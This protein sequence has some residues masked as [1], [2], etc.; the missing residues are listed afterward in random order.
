MI[1]MTNNS[2]IHPTQEDKKLL[3]Q[4]F[5][6]KDSQLR[7]T[8]ILRFL[9]LVH[10]A[11]GRLGVTTNGH[12]DYVDLVNQGVLGLID[13]VDRYDPSFKTQFSTYAIPKVRG[14]ILDFMRGQ[15]WLPRTARQR[16]KLVQQA[17]QDLW[18]NLHR[19]PT[20]EEIAEYLEIPIDKARQA[21]VD[22]SHVFISLDSFTLFDQEDNVSIH[23]VL[24]DEQSPNPAAS[25][26]ELDLKS[27]LEQALLQIGERERLVLSLYY[28][29][30]FTLKEI[31]SVLGV[32][33]SR[34]CQLHA[35]AILNL[36]TI[37]STMNAQKSES[38]EVATHV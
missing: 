38:M 3:D 25:Y 36:K 35:K 5:E 8:I 7:E 37:I 28:Y 23:E 15:D 4:F 11:I 31:G 32:T 20:D 13:A 33:E 21:L 16:A 10:Y 12:I 34:V 29:D 14:K 30:E 9:P 17:T 2:Q 27:Q 1:F 18:K 19:S 26:E 6:T 24:P 22:A